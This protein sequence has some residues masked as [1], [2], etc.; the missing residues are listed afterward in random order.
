MIVPLK[1][2]KK[3]GTLLSRL[4]KLTA[5]DSMNLY[6]SIWRFWGGFTLLAN[7]EEDTK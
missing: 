5:F 4:S 6:Y 1:K 2:K 3:K 7:S